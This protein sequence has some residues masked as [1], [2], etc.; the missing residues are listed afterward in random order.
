MIPKKQAQ[1]KEFRK[2]AGNK[3]VGEVTVDMMYGGMRGIKG[4]LYMLYVC[5]V[6]YKY[7]TYYICYTIYIIHVIKVCYTCYYTYFKGMLNIEI[8]DLYLI[9]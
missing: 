1:I 5:Y 7:I 3:V 9:K 4:M 2:V 6:K 8:T